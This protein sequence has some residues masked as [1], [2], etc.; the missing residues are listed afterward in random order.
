M[1]QIDLEFYLSDLQRLQDE[2]LAEFEEINAKMQAVAQQIKLAEAVKSNY[3]KHFRIAQAT[4]TYIDNELRAKFAHLSIKEMLI[5]IALE[6][7]GVL[8]LGDA[9]IKLVKA[10]VFKDDRNAATSIAPVLN[11]SDELFKRIARG[12][13]L[14]ERGSSSCK[15]EMKTAE[16]VGC[17]TI[18]RSPGKVNFDIGGIAA[19]DAWDSANF[20]GKCLG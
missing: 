6:S 20:R 3:C 14:L 9:R 16:A 5:Q 2:L 13:Y 8:D 10:G 19:S 17:K 4:V 7:G 12:V 1:T 11:R 15:V 18:S